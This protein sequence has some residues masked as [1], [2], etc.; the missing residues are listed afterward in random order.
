MDY[1]VVERQQLAGVQKRD[2]IGISAFRLDAFGLRCRRF[3]F[4]FDA[5]GLRRSSFLFRLDA[6]SLRCRRTA[7][8]WV[9]SRG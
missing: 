8:G 1:V 7:S 4:R 3:L 6:C 2:D 9:C 5:F